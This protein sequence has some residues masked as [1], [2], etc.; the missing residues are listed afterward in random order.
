[1]S[2]YFP[3]LAYHLALALSCPSCKLAGGEPGTIQVSL[4]KSGN[5]AWA[6][7]LH[8]CVSLPQALLCWLQ[9]MGWPCPY[10]S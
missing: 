1:M 8:V 9:K 7:M 4:S 5:G 2:W 3:P 6:T 10:T